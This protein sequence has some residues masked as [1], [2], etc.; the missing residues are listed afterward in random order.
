MAK[1]EQL[2]NRNKAKKSEKKNSGKGRLLSLLPE[3]LIVFGVLSVLYSTSHTYFRNRALQINQAVVA[4][5]DEPHEDTSKVPVHIKI[6]WYVDIPVQKEVYDN[7]D[8]TISAAT[9]SYLAQSSRPGESGNIIIYGHNKREILGNIRVLIGGEI[10]TLTTADG[11]EHQYRVTETTRV[12]PTQVE[13]LQ[14]TDEEVLTIYTC[15][16]FMD[17]QRFIVRAVPVEI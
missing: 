4:Q 6:P 16:G 1:K 10:I 13:Y 9:A 2:N 15:D 14:P 11:T 3:F 8:W 7:G 5:Y 17:R 12:E